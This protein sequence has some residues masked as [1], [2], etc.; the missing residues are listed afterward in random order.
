MRNATAKQLRDIA[1]HTKGYEGP[2]KRRYYR[3][4]KKRLSR[5]PSK[6]R[7]KFFN[8]FEEV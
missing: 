7:H 4:L 6:D 1:Y 2:K 5:T 3:Y 8:Q